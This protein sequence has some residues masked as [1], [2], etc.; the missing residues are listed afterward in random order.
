MDKL[1]SHIISDK[2]RDVTYIIEIQ[3]HF[4]LKK[5]VYKAMTKYIFLV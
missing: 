5:L 1:R 3:N 4:T 2:P